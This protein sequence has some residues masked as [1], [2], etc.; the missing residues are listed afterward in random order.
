MGGG[1]GGG[2]VPE[3]AAQ[4]AQAG[5]AAQEAQDYFQRWVPVQ[6]Y[7]K[8]RIDQLAPGGAQQQQALGATNASTQADFSNAQ[9][10]VTRGLAER[11]VTAGSGRALMANS[12]LAAAKAQSLGTGLADTSNAVESE[13]LKGLQ[14]FVQLGRG[15][16]TSADSGMQFLAEA[17]GKQ[18]EADAQL[19]AQNAAGVGQAIGTGLG[20]GAGYGL[21]NYFNGGSGNNNSNTQQPNNPPAQPAAYG[22]SQ[23]PGP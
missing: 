7:F 11:G 2:T 13:Y 14:E 4:Q 5:V 21:N 9:Q 10:Q 8:G 19:A 16:K 6:N 23:P 18:A 3:T 20:I 12:G 22:Y 17:S 1:G 15:E